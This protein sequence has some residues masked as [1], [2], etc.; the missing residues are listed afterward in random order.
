[1]TEKITHTGNNILTLFEYDAV[2]SH[3]FAW[4]R[5]VE[6]TASMSA[7]VKFRQHVGSNAGIPLKRAETEALLEEM[8]GIAPRPGHEREAKRIINALND[9]FGVV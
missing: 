3:V 1:M 5:I 6:E 2:L 8:T 9:I 4:H 7:A